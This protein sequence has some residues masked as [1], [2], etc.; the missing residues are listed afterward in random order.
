MRAVSALLLPNEILSMSAQAARRLLETGDGDCA[1]L[2]LALLERGG[3]A[4]AARERLGWPEHRVEAAYGRLVT[5]GL[6]SGA[7]PAAPEGPPEPD[8]LPEYSR[9]DLINALDRDPP[10]VALYQEVERLLNRPLSD[11]DLKCLY[12]IYDYLALPAEVIMLLTG[13]ALQTARRQKGQREGVTVRMPQV[14]KLAFRWK[15]MGLDT[16]E[17]AEDYLRQQERVDARE[18]AILS[19]VGVTQRRPAVGKEREFIDQWVNLGLSDQLIAMAYERTVYQK[20]AMNWPYMNKILLSWHQAGFTTPEQVRAGDKPPKRA[21][22][23]SGQGAKGLA[24]G[25]D[26]EATPDRIQKSA[27]WLDQFLEQQKKT[28]G[29]R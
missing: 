7:M 20:G 3:D 27:D 19:A 8:R 5:L 10:F 25:V 28:E 18:W 16:V 22:A 13:F 9:G 15:R 23:K 2:Y 14:Q 1:L 12:T 4:Q 6:A 17:R 26:Y 24:P 21:A 11:N 29:K